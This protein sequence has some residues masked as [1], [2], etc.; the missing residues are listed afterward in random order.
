[1]S[2]PQT[3]ADELT[4]LKNQLRLVLRVARD[5]A[6]EICVAEEDDFGFMAM[7]FLCRQIDHAESVLLL[8]PRRDSILIARSMFDG[9]CQ[10]L[11]AYRDKE[12]R[13]HQWR[14]FAWVYDWKL[15]QVQKA[16]GNEVDEEMLVRIEKV[17][18]KH[19]H[20]FKKKGNNH[21]DPYHKTW[22]GSKKLQDIA[23]EVE[24]QELYATAYSAMSDWAHWGL[25]GIAEAISRDN[26]RI[27]FTT[28]SDKST[29]GA[30]T[31]SYQALFQTTQMV[32]IHLHLNKQASLGKLYDDFIRGMKIL[33]P[34]S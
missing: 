10:L 26:G 32:D 33:R 9:L 24:G 28:N 27:T 1:M 4:F 19:G 31:M 12:V 11:W 3:S 29:W 23:I 17:L 5:C 7:T 18:E 16:E 13:G 34:D 15:A 20:I 30:L 6:T 8:L 22:L 21:K 25:A 2:I 14:S